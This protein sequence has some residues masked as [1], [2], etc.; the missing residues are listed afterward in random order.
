MNDTS[1]ISLA[2]QALVL[3]A[4][5]AG[6]IL[7]VSLVVGLAVSVVQSATQL[8][9]YTLSF[10]PKILGVALVLL[11]AGHW[12]IGQAIGFTDQLMA[13]VPRLLAGR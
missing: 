6:P 12:M 1:V 3:A 10:V 7:V 5:L 2:A 4:K 13:E 11:L 9:E 8:Q